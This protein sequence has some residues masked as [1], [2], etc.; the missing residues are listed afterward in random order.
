MEAY[1]NKI[2]SSSIIEKQPGSSKLNTTFQFNVSGK[3]Q[4]FLSFKIHLHDL[5]RFYVVLKDSNNNPF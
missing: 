3:S 4:H 5:V 2:K 1:P